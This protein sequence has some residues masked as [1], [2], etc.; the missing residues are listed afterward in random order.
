MDARRIHDRIPHHIDFIQPS[1]DTGS[2]D[3]LIDMNMAYGRT[4]SSAGID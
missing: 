1:V 2:F 4:Q 3:N